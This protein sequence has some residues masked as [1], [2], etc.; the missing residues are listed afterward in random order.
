MNTDFDIIIVGAGLVGLTTALACAES[1]SSVALIDRK[2]IEGG[3]D[4]RAS[5]LSATSLCLFENLGVDIA[6]S[7][8]AIED[9]LIT[10]GV[11]NSPWRL[12][13]EREDNSE[14]LGALIE[15]PRLKTA[16]IDRVKR[17]DLIATFAPVDI[18]RTHRD[19]SGVIVET[20]QST[21][22]ARLLI[23]ADGRDSVL[24]RKAGI[25]VQRFDYDSASLVTT[26]S[27][28]LP[29][30]GL[31]WQR[32]IQGGALAL[33]PLTGQRCQVVWSGP[34][35]AIQAAND[36]T[37]AA[38]L[39]LLNEK[40]EGY[41]GTM[42]LLAPRQ[43][44]PLRLQLADSFTTERLALVGDA[45]HVIHPLA[46]QGLN[47]GLRD[48]AALADGIKMA[49]KTGQDIGVAGLMDYDLW[50]NA[51][52]RAFGALT[53]AIAQATMPKSAALGH[54]RRLGLS[55]LNRSSGM[56]ASFKNQAS[57]QRGTPPDLMQRR[58]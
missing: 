23:A 14:N 55:M 3:A 13:F 54:L 42:S 11:P 12:H 39:D 8:Q 21:L 34:A 46:G 32:M 49:R 18:L 6:G 5:A 24:R 15:N 47:L 25:T 56:K 57:G 20:D 28:S 29:H 51:D 16:L 43:S 44:Y 50:R 33:L 41:L 48:A 9:M 36:V 31:A 26:I 58:D 37:E 35:A 40:M 27:H 2:Q 53:H 19:V 30:D 45:A 7:L 38:F 10:E 52:T 1:G 22:T 4:G 17:S